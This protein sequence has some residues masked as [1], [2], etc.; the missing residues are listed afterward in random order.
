MRNNSSGTI[1]R[2]YWAGHAVPVSLAEAILQAL[3]REDVKVLIEPTHPHPPL[4]GERLRTEHKDVVN[5]K[6]SRAV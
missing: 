6:E 1:A 4:G 3:R 2:A 5:D